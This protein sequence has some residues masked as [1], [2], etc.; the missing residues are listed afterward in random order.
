MLKFLFITRSLLVVF[1]LIP[2]SLFSQLD[3]DNTTSGNIPIDELGTG[4]F[5]GY[6]GG[7]YPGG[8]NEMPA[9]HKQAGN[10]IAKKIKPLNE[11]GAV[12]YEN[13]KIVFIGM[14]AST[15]NNTFNTFK[16]KMQN[17]SLG[18]YNPCIKYISLCIGG[19]G[20]ESMIPPHNTYYW[21][22][23]VHT[24]LPDAGVT[25]A[26]V[27][28]G[29]IK[30]ASKDDSIPEFPLQADSIYSKYILAIQRMKDSFPNMKVL[31][32]AS[33][34][35]GGY[36]GDLSDNADLA[37]EPASYYGGFAV[38]W[39]IESQ[40]NGDPALRYKGADIQAP[41]LSWGPYYW[42]D[43]ITPRATDGLTWVCEDFDPTGGGF[44]LSEQGK[45]KE[46]TMLID[47]LYNNNASKRWF[48]SGPTWVSCSLYERNGNGV[49]LMAPSSIQKIKADEIVLYPSPNTGNFYISFLND[50]NTSCSISVINSNGEIIRK[51]AFEHE[52]G[53]VNNHIQLGDIPSGIYYLIVQSGEK[54]ISKS[55]V[56]Q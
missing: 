43:G 10:S 29:W 8:S 5:M 47:Y 36:A 28:V 16:T 7:L 54:T 19:K 55:F 14:G 49:P 25:A 26:Q 32:L 56:I 51:D 2:I 41:W 40:I 50:E 21:E 3:C 53:I 37:G 4:Y 44:H 42:A 34:A 46:A 20:L 13:G 27:Q 39:V 18:L 23:L 6:Q 22:Y 52:A 1:L 17:D 15:A 30:S 45:D 31:Y 24:A 9:V 12:D 35:Y 33:H 38:K 48:R 11:A